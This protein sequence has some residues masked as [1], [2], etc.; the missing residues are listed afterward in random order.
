MGEGGSRKGGR[1][2]SYMYSEDEVSHVH[3]VGLN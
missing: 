2:E 3:V 1:E